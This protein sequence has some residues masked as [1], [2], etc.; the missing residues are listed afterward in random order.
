[1]PRSGIARSYGSSIFGFL[2]N[3]YTVFHSGCA[4]LHSHHQCRR[5]PFPPYPLQ[6]LLFEDLLMMAI[7]VRVG[8]YLM[9]VLNCISVMTS[10]VEHLFM[11]PLAMCMSSSEKCLLR[12]SAHALIF[13]FF[14]MEKIGG[15]Y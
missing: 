4:H 14:W 9:V 11:C 7:L 15:R 10:D 6:P 3:L 5:V 13:S 2:R 8:W 1:M 12:S